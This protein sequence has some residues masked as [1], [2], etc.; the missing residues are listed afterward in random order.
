MHYVT[1]KA[2]PTNNSMVY[3]KSV[4]KLDSIPLNDDHVF[5]SSNNSPM[6]TSAVFRES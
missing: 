5:E 6:R 4:Q 1:D 2:P 3:S